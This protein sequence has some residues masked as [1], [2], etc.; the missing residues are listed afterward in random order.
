MSNPVHTVLNTRFRIHWVEVVATAAVCALVATGITVAMHMATPAP[1]SPSTPV[2]ATE[3]STDCLWDASIQG[4]G[5]GESFYVDANGTQYFVRDNCASEL[6]ALAYDT[7]HNVA[8]PRVENDAN[9][10]NGLSAYEFANA[11]IANAAILSDLKYN[12]GCN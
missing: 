1:T 12:E 9:S 2:C 10:D 8:I 7:I 4:N 6:Y 11:T 3:D 5:T